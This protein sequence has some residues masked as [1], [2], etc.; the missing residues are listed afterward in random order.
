M[1]SPITSAER[2][3]VTRGFSRGRYA[4]T[5]GLVAAALALFVLW[6]LNIGHGVYALSVL[7]V[8]AAALTFFGGPERRARTVTVSAREIRI[9][10]FHRIGTVIER[11]ELAGAVAEETPGGRGRP[12]ALLVLTPRDPGTFFTRHRELRSVRIDGAAHVPVGTSHETVR[13]LN[14]ALAG[15]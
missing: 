2:T 9:T 5:L 6:S 8:A 13:E 15:N 14:E 12:Q 1:K 10:R 3:I 4:L 11:S 7:A